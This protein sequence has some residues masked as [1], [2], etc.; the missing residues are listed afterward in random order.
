MGGQ[1]G[2]KELKDVQECIANASLVIK[3]EVK[4]YLSSC[5]IEPIYFITQRLIYA[6][7]KYYP[8]KW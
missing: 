8:T 3:S 2:W 1:G 4:K 5:M 7:L 6:T